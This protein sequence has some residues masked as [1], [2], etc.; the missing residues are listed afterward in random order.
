MTAFLFYV[1]VKPLSYLPLG[2][3]YYLSDLLYVL[4]YHL[5]RYRRRLVERNIAKSFPDKNEAEV[6]RIAQGFY[7]HFSDF[8]VESLRLFSISQKEVI[9]RCRVV[10]PEVIDPFFKNGRS[11]ILVGGHYNNWEMLAVA[12]DPQVKH[13]AVGIYVPLSNS[14]LNRTF[15]NS[16][17]RFGLGLV[18][19]YDVSSFFEE[20]ND[21]RVTTIFGADQSP[22]WTSKNIYWTTFLNQETGVMFGTEKYAKEYNQPVV[23]TRIT[24]KSRGHYEISFELITEN[25]AETGHFEITEKHTRMLEKQIQEH[26]EYW[27]WIHDRWKRKRKDFVAYGK[28]DKPVE[29]VES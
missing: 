5:I 11:I 14:F 18:A 3:T 7:R 13:H 21:K 8:I 25:P 28:Q 24:K 26:P 4:T 9:K 16:R 2:V 23:F 10:N 20:N 1:F 17:S 12:M 15:I 29:S 6:K 19:K 22:F 27:L